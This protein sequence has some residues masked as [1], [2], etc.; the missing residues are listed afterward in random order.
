MVR[1]Y[2]F[3]GN[4]GVEY[5][6]GGDEYCR[7]CGQSIHGAKITHPL[8]KSWWSWKF[9]LVIPVFA[10]G[11]MV[12]GLL[13]RMSTEVLSLLPFGSTL[14]LT[15]AKLGQSITDGLCAVLFTRAV[16]PHHKFGISIAAAV[17]VT[18]GAAYSLMFITSTNYFEGVGS[19]TVLWNV[20]LILLQVIA[21]WVAVL[22]AHSRT[23]RAE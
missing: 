3:C 22:Y 4:C 16:A 9:L 5:T 18:F 10:I 1:R 8:G 13:V 21:A 23:N 7:S 6:P 12:P 19:A 2:Q 15:M 14:F 20:V 11:Y 17:V